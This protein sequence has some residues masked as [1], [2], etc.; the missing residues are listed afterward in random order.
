M[1]KEMELKALQGNRISALCESSYGITQ[2]N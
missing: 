2:N 1:E